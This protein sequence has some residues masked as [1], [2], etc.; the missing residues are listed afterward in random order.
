MCL[1]FSGHFTGV[2]SFAGYT[3]LPRMRSL[4]VWMPIGISFI[5]A[6]MAEY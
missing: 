1:A 4:K 6:S 5:P 3:L 2:L